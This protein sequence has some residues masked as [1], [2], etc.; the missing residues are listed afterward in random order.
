MTHAR[1]HI[2]THTHTNISNL[3]IT[4]IQFVVSKLKS[5]ARVFVS[6]ICIHVYG[7]KI[8]KVKKEE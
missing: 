1:T 2:H 8:I 5:I 3:Y 4:H 7:K 6:K